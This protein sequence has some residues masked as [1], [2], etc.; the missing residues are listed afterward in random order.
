VDAKIDGR[1]A[2]GMRTR[3]A[4]VTALMDLV[5]LGDL[6]PTAQR[7]ADRAGVS[8]RS[9]Y[10]H[11]TDVDGLFEQAGARL[12][13][14]VTRLAADIDPGMDL[15]EKVARVVTARAAALEMI[16]PFSRAARVMDPTSPVINE[17]RLVMLR[18]A[19]DRIAVVFG[20]EI[21]KAPENQRELLLDSIDCLATWQT[22]DHLRELGCT[23]ERAKAV[24]AG[25][26]LKLLAST[27]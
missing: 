4:I 6:N 16:T 23:P 19:R 17:W 13:E 27:S 12:H 14:H 21:A 10:Q 24:M 2:R 5:A 22:W 1:R 3:D 8:V 25:A 26:M 20:P 18:E 15:A 11:F 7:I 9:V